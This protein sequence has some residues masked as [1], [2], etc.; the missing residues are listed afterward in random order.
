MARLPVVGGDADA[1]GTLVNGFLAVDHNADGTLINA[2]RLAPMVSG[3]LYS[4]ST[5]GLGQSGV[6]GNVSFPANTL[7]MSPI[8]LTTDVT[9][10]KIGC[11]VSTGVAGNARLGIFTLNV[12][13]GAATLVLDCGT[14]STS[15]AGNKELAISQFVSAGAYWLG[16]VTDVAVT[17]IQAAAAHGIRH[18]ASYV[19]VGALSKTYTYAALASTTAVSTSVTN[20]PVI[21]VGVA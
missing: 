20:M 16:M 4:T 19:M 13:T 17:I 8:Q 1:W 12:G 18:D 2:A 3:S 15:T 21:Y 11:Y 14:F 10:N 5:H 7:T 9:L 6:A